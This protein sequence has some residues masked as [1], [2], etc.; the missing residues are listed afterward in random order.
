MSVYKQEVLTD[1][2][3]DCV[4]E[5]EL[6]YFVSELLVRGSEVSTSTAFESF[7]FPTV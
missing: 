4:R 6:K 1:I 2:T 3:C 7:S 5:Q